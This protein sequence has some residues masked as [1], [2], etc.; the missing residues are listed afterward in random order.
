MKSG[1]P[2]DRLWTHANLATFDPRIAVP[3]GLHEDG[4]LAVKDGRIAA[5]LP[6][7]APEVRTFQGEAIDCRGR[8][9][10]PGLIDCHTHLVYGGSRAAEWELRLAGVPY[11]EIAKRGGG[12]LSTVRATRELDEDHLVAAALPRLAALIREGVTCVEIKSGYGLTISDELKMLRVARRLASELPCEVSPS[13]LAAHA[14]PPEF[15]GRNDDYVSLIIDEIL[16]LV[17]REKLAE[18]VDVFCE[19]IAFS[20]PQCERIFAAAKHHG[21]AVKGH[22]E[23]L[24]NSYGAELVARHGGWSADHLEYLDDAGIAVMAGARTVAVLLPGAFY[25][26]REKQKPPVE[27]LR[28]AGVRMAVGSDLNPGTSPFA[29]LRLAMNMACVLFNL[30]P[31]EAFA[32]VTREAAKALGRA[33]RLGTLETGKVANFVVWDTS[34]PAEIILQLGGNPVIER[35]FRGKSNHART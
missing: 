34:H 14:I 21:L 15:V 12:I 8:L 4:A 32:G 10:T 27:R 3:F 1:D 31:E 26:L 30:T 17:A 7:D 35:V 16:P 33:D 29:S 24:S 20:L 2:F 13:L 25:F 19:S 22:V 9:L 18:A 23:Q 5:I 28:A 6:M 11:V